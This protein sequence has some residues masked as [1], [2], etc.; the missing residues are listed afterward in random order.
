MVA[1]RYKKEFKPMQNAEEYN[2]LTDL[3]LSETK[4]VNNI[5][6]QFLKYARPPS[7]NKK[8]IEI[9]E[10]IKDVAAMAETQCNS[11][12]LKFEVDCDCEQS[13]IVDA[14]LMKQ[15]LLN[16][17]QNSVEATRAG[18]ISLKVRK[19]KKNV[20][21]RIS[22]TG[23]GISEDQISKIFNL[24]FTTKPSGT[25]MGLSIVQQI[26]SQHNG[27]IRVESKVGNGTEFIIEIPAGQ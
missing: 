8:K 11:K 1:Q 10:I 19:L 12:G 26:V 25:G 27:T 16:I 3:L 7:L 22:D 24:Y 2:S 20:E 4:R 18:N 9:R 15:A 23:P 21:I 13:V 5:I 14:D 17:L 6:Q